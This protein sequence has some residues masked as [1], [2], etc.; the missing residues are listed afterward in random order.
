MHSSSCYR[1][2]CIA[3]LVSD[4]FQ[5]DSPS[6]DTVCYKAVQFHLI[7]MS[8]V[9]ILWI[10]SWLQRQLLKKRLFAIT[11]GD[12]HFDSQSYFVDSYK[13]VC[14]HANIWYPGHLA[15]WFYG[16]RLVIITYNDFYYK[17]LTIMWRL[18]CY[19]KCLCNDD[20]VIVIWISM[21]EMTGISEAFHHD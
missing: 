7:T 20:D 18:E 12:K 10:V 13:Q 11:L 1:C 19:Y 8:P 6:S 14:F 21:H 16:G 3:C 2:R 9:G 17:Y 4:P 15:I 5:C